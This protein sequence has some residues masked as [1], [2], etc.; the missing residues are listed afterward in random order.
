VAVKL[1]LNVL[2]STL[3]LVLLRPGVQEAAEQGRLLASGV[4]TLPEPGSMIYPPIVSTSL[5]LVA[6]LLSVFKPWGRLRGR[7]P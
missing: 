2:L 6:F 7:R 4:D 5:L 1:F 3:V